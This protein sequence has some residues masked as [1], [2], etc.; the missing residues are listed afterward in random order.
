MGEYGV[1]QSVPRLEDAALLT[2]RGL[3]ID[4]DDGIR[5]LRGH[6]LRAPHAHARIVSI[7]VTAA[8]RAPGVA[9]VLTGADY[10]ADGLRPIPHIGPPVKPRGGAELDAAPYYPIVS[11]RVRHVGEGVAFVVADTLDQAKDAAELIE[12]VYE[13]L[14]AVTATDEALGANAP[15]VWEGCPDNEVF[16]YEIGDRA[17]TD[18]AFARADHVVRRR[19]EITRVLANAM[20]PRG[21]L[22][23]YDPRR[24][25]FWLRAP[26]Q[27]PFVARA[28]LAKQILGIDER[29]VHVEVDDVGGSFGIKANLYPEYVMAV[30]AARRI[31]RDVKWT[32]ERSEGFLSDFHA[33]DNFTDVEL[34]LDSK[35]LFL[36]LRVRTTVNIGAYLSPLGAGPAVNN[37]GT[38]AGVYRTPVA[39]VE[40]RGALSHTQPTAPYRGAG[41]PEAA[42]VIERIIDAAA[43]QLGID[44]VELRRRNTIAPDQLPFATPLGFTYDSGEFEA[45]LDQALANADAA[46]FEAR[47]AES[48]T[49]G[50]LRGLGIANAIERAAPP[51]LEYAE[52]RFDPS[53][54]ATILSGATAQGQGHMTTFAQV[55]DEQLGLAPE[56]LRFVQG[57][58]ERVA[59]GFGSGGSRI[60]ALGTAALMLAADRI[61]AK[62][63]IIAAHLLET[64]ET[65]LDFTDGRFVIAGTDRAI[66]LTEVA[67]ISFQPA[68][69][70]AGVDPGLY[71]T[72]TY[73]ADVACYP[74]GC[75]VCEIEIDRETGTTEI[76]RYVVVDDFG[77]LINP[78]LVKGQV[79]GG[80]AQGA[81][82]ALMEAMVYDPDSGQMIAGS[83]MD[84][85]MPR[86]DD[87]CA[88]EV[89]SNPVPTATNP[90]GVKGAGEAGNV[91]ALPAVISAVDDALAPLGVRDFD[92]PATPERV[93]RAIQEA[94]A[95]PR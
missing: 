13:P 59:Y 5:P 9:A 94:S 57:D 28:V 71:E 26:I 64:A 17:A 92:M 42:Y 66:E 82:Q 85:A 45:N 75:H 16:L 54:T 32:S 87:L 18:A 90:L 41:R 88:I 61:L 67:K 72:G 76:V 83:F 47:R 33:R 58:T 36:G 78:L 29:D 22:A 15:S 81:G 77:T 27:H 73:R 23:R 68:R 43:T 30:W 49:R 31:G 50:K 1:G 34:A 55:M 62:A 6:V 63:R 91:G 53:G 65:D 4:D 51:G 37:L 3:F 84:Y 93:W 20:E 14:P 35:G 74:N 25:S 21:C 80:V 19:L 10:V 89:E 7:D 60:S 2:G 95:T 11:D 79:H 52:I 39:H 44:R 46:G 70:P 24:R 38:L 12:V 48:A 56:S 69:L 86:G 40:V 8:A